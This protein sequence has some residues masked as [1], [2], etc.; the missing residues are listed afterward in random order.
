MRLC[1]KKPAGRPSSLVSLGASRP[2]LDPT[3]VPRK[4]PWF[5][6]VQHQA[7]DHST[8]C[9]RA[10]SGCCRQRSG[11]GCTSRRRVRAAAAYRCCHRPDLC[12]LSKAC[13]LMMVLDREWHP[14]RICLE[15]HPLS[16][17]QFMS[18]FVA[19]IPLVVYRVKDPDL[20][21]LHTAPTIPGRQQK[22]TQGSRH[23]FASLCFSLS[24]CLRQ[25]QVDGLSRPTTIR[26][27]FIWSADSMPP[28]RN[29]LANGVSPQEP[30]RADKRLSPKQPS[31]SIKRSSVQRCS[32][33][34]M[35]AASAGASAVSRENAGAHKDSTGGTLR[36]SA[37]LNQ[38]KRAA[39]VDCV[40]AERLHIGA[41]NFQSLLDVQ[42]VHLTSKERTG[43]GTRSTTGASR[44][45]GSLT[46]G[47][48]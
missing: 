23:A 36:T 7:D 17:L 28:A 41:D 18:K 38:W 33:S 43:G 46:N 4:R 47:L 9:W 45:I 20:G 10:G 11:R 14:V 25:L 27:S 48:P 24:R 42:P 39:I 19:V 26:G 16:N 13:M 32:A 1:T 15:A 8:S 22:G 35:V 6:R 37:R 44:R 2:T 31:R 5:M 30:D 21:V 3:D 29:G 34:A 12:R 40:A